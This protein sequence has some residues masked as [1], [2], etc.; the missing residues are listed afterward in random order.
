MAR[1][2]TQ[3]TTKYLNIPFLERGLTHAGCDCWGLYRLILMEQAN[4][5]LPEWID[6]QPGAD[7]AKV[8]TILANANSPQWELINP[9]YEQKFDVVL[10]RGLVEDKNNDRKHS[11]PIHIGCVVTS[12]ILIQIERGSGVTIG[13]YKTHF[14]IR[15][16]V[17]GFYRYAGVT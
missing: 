3:W 7:A 12:D 1:H 5:Q 10:M 6:I 11:A 17:V 13:N 16:R 14:K 2:E 4:I 9:G 8:E 15:R